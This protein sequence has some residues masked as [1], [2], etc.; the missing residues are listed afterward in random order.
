MANNGFV[1]F[2]AVREFS[3]ALV[4]LNADDKELSL[5]GAVTLLFCVLII[6]YKNTDFI[7]NL[8]KENNKFVYCAH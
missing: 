4:K 7:I 8:Q 5:R 3:F 2:A 6:L 1:A